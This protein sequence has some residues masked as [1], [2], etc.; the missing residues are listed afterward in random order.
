MRSLSHTTAFT[1]PCLAALRDSNRAGSQ[2]WR[3][4]AR[5]SVSPRTPKPPSAEP[6]Q[7]ARPRGGRGHSA[8]SHYPIPSSPQTDASGLPEPLPEPEAAAVALELLDATGGDARGSEAQGVFGFR[9]SGISG[10]DVAC[11]P[12][13]PPTTALALVE[14]GTG[15]SVVGGVLAAE[16]LLVAD[17]AADDALALDAVLAVLPHVSVCWRS[18]RCG[19]GCGCGECGSDMIMDYGE[20]WSSGK[21]KKSHQTI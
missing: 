6:P 17:N 5:R 16:L 8:R 3:G 13:P 9:L 18:G 15:V 1:P 21:L 10:V 19:S 4:R 7:A 14:V 11:A 12:T 2:R 20:L